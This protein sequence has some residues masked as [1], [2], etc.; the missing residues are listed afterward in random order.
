MECTISEK[1]HVPVERREFGD[2]DTV[3]MTDLFVVTT[4]RDVSNGTARHS[5][6]RV[7]MGKGFL[8]HR[9]VYCGRCQGEMPHGR[10][11]SL[12]YT[13]DHRPH[14]STRH[15]QL[16]FTLTQLKAYWDIAERP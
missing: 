6:G 15:W 14:A 5:M 16:Q 9:H 2:N 11:P 10:W 4:W 7:Q 3:R 8:W 1:R 13:R 12:S